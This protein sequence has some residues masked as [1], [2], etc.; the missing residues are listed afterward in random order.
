MSSS[1][2]VVKC[3]NCG[4]DMLFNPLTGGLSCPYC[5]SQK[6]ITGILTH[7]RN[8]FS[9]REASVVDT[10][11]DVYKCSNCGGE[12]VF[13]ACV[14]ATK[15]PFCSA[16]NIVRLKD[17]DGLK[18]DGILPFLYT[19]EMAYEAGKA[20]IKKKFFA[21]SSFKKSFA[22]DNFN[23][24]YVPSYLFSSDTC[25]TYTCRLGTYYYV[26]VGS[27][28]NR[29]TVRKIRWRT[30]SGELSKFFPDVMVEAT[31]QLNQNELSKISPYD[32][33]NV[34][35]YQKEYVAGFS[36]EQCDATLDSGFE[37][38][39]SIM[40]NH[41]KG[42]ILSRYSYDVVGEYSASTTYP[43]VAFNYAL[44]PVWIYGCKHKDKVY[45]YI[46]NGRNGN[47]YGKYPLSPSRISITVLGVL[48]IIAGI[49]CIIL[50]NN[51]FFG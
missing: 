20:W 3:E 34:I 38:A 33:G 30:Y 26:T 40:D 32:V 41:I 1:P 22:A 24:V 51:G 28:K 12:V 37:V 9:E 8:F 5:D 6:E 46:V 49:A 17:Y 42:E 13:D 44:V 10:T 50:A 35:G 15:C 11:Q 7:K 48:G 29:R 18:P 47:S 23:G 36:A 45:R 4:A 31:R 43:V 21:L 39:K 25:T 16:T 14:T 19:K 27:G 2:S